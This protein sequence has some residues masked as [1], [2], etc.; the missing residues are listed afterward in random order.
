MA[1]NGTAIFDQI[2]L[3]AVGWTNFQ[4]LVTATDTNSVL[5]FGFRDDTSSFGL[6]D[7]Q[8]L[9]LASADGSPIIAT[10][11]ANQVS[12]QGGNGVFSVLSSGQLPL[13]YQW[14]FDGANIED[15]TNATLQLTNLAVGQ[16]GSYGVV[17]S[18]SLGSATSSYALLSVLTGEEVLITFDD[19]PYRLVPV[20]AGYNNLTWSNF[21]YLNGVVNRTSG[22]GP[23]MVSVPKVAY[24]AGGSPAAI[25]ASSPFALFS[26]YMTA[27]WNDNLQVEAQ[28]FN[29]STLVYD[30]SYTLSAAT[31]TLITFNYVG[32][33]SVK[34]ISS[35]GIPHN[36]YKGS[37]TQFAMDNINA[38][39]TPIPPT[40]PPSSIFLLYS[41]EGFD[42]GHPSSALTE[43]ADGNFYGTTQY[44]GTYGDG[45]VFRMTTNGSLTTLALSIT[46]MAPTRSA[47]AGAGE[48][49]Q[50]LRHDA[51]RRHDR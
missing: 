38:Y 18:N 7:V 12:V 8:V 46:T 37:G 39:V 49:R 16:A 24:N 21:D 17:V 4:F 40:P 35:G 34:F 25:S 1:W 51:V 13:F 2:N 50:S 27:A 32:V 47:R 19:L 5:Q 11:P 15:A 29:G 28:G 36:G 6:D 22:Y 30:N 20:P 45:T 10:Q 42:G 43:A 41:F 23:A 9:P 48:R 14:Q 31:P 3:A 44:G 33:T 26:A